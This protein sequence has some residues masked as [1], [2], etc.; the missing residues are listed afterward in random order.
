M[1]CWQLLCRL[2]VSSM[3]LSQPS[4]ATRKQLWEGFTYH[5]YCTIYYVYCRY[6][7]YFIYVIYIWEGRAKSRESSQPCRN[8]KVLCI[9]LY[10]LFY[11]YMF[12]VFYRTPIF[13]PLIMFRIISVFLSFKV[14]TKAD[15]P[16]DWGEWK[17][18]AVVGA[19]LW[20]RSRLTH[21]IRI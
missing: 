10:T 7:I 16:S 2:S 13:L 6:Y 11:S 21:V 18:E 12:I 8:C 19:F 1:S 15:I 20:L 14:S 9:N 5:I 4:V 3:D 17:R